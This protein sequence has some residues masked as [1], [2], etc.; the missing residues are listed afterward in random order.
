MNVGG[1]AGM[2]LR[3]L[4]ARFS[5]GFCSPDVEERERE[6]GVGERERGGGG[7]PVKLT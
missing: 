5:V 2:S 6:G 1:F 3:D 7:D 4:M